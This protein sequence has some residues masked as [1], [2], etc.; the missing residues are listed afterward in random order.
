MGR[1]NEELQKG[2][3]YS[4]Q[5]EDS[6]WTPKLEGETLYHGSPNEIEGGVVKPGVDGR[7][8]AATHPKEAGR[9]GEHKAPINHVYEVTPVDPKEIVGVFGPRFYGGKMVKHFHSGLGFNVV[10]KLD[11]KELE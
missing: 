2:I 11:P 3:H 10:R 8:W 5:P 7:A 4:P 6:E 9:Y 1:S